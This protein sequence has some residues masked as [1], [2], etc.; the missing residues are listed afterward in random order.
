MDFQS[1]KAFLGR[2]L[3]SVWTY[4]LARWGL[5]LVFVYAGAV[6]L[7]EPRAFAEVVGAYGLLPAGLVTPM[8]VLL[9]AAE[10]LAG[11]GLVLDKRGSLAAIGA[12]TVMFIVV[13]AYGIGLGLDVD[14]G[15]YGPGDPEG[16]AFHGLRQALLRDIG[17]LSV[18][19][20][21][22]WWRRFKAALPGIRIR[23][24][25]SSPLVKLEQHR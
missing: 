25:G 8:A 21:V 24:G 7:A 22:H 10:V 6:K 4:R 16:E 13:L 3:G 2:W 23:R 15:C 18:V 19:V 12:M 1:P 11:I 20:Y 5:G 9:P 14:C 17:M